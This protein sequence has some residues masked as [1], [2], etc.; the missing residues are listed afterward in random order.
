MRSGK[1]GAPTEIRTAG[2]AVRLKWRQLR[3]RP[4]DPPCARRNLV[5]GLA[6]GASLEVD[7][8]RL[9]C[10]RFVCLHDPRLEDE[11]TGRGPVAGIDAAAVARL[12]LRGA[13]GEAPLLLDELAEAVRAGPTGAS[14]RVQLDLQA[15]ATEIDAGVGEAFAAALAGLEDR[16]ILSGY[17]WDAVSRLGGRAP[18]LALGYDP[19]EDGALGTGGAA[20]DPAAV[21]RL[22][23]ETAPG[24]HT[25]YLPRELVRAS[26]ERGD[27]LVARLRAWGH[28]VDCWTIDHGAP[29]AAADMAAAIAAGCDQITT[30]TA[31]AWA[32]ANLEGEPREPR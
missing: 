30:N 15:A 22:V 32:A 24:A 4:D 9:A 14:A 5:A 18:G 17:D 1:A 2:R 31:L 13:A 7:I 28:L 27:G 29:D 6:A 26:H 20:V 19:T 8:R 25:I 12:E 16:F 11:T 10:G 23:R 21:L 3:R